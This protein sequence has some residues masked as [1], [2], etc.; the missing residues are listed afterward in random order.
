MKTNS[1]FENEFQEE[2]REAKKLS[3][4]K[5]HKKLS[6]LD[7]IPTKKTVI[8]TIFN[9]NQ[10]VVVEVLDRAN[11]IC[12]RCE[13]PA[14]FLKDLDN[15]P[16]L[17]VHHIKPLAKGGNDTIDNAVGICPNCHRQAHYGKNSY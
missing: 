6:N 11:G 5:R 3:K 7:P 14:P 16:Y 17:E 4:E 8:Q 12:E 15:N 10:Y 2:I 9:R 1:D 13:K